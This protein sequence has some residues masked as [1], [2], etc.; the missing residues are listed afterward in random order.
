MSWPIATAALRLKA[1][2]VDLPAD[3]E[4]PLQARGLVVFAHGS[5]SSR[6]SVRNRFVAEQLQQAGLATVL[7]DLLSEEEEGRDGPAGR[8]RFAIPLLRGRLSAVLDA[9]A[10]RPELQGLPL[11]LFGAST[12][13]AAALGSAA[14]RPERVRAVVCRGGRPDLAAPW[15]E[16]VHCPTLLVV[17]S[18]DRTVL[19]LNH[20]AA[21]R[22]GGPHRLAVVDGAGHLFEEPDALATVA[23]LAADWFGRWLTPGATADG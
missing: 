3:L 6:R 9:L 14:E 10:E 5:G 13:A 18:L 22:L 20:G 1:D 8:L 7:F 2:G 19:E 23:E 11:G 21:R 16:Q 12:G 15:L 4:M 17:G